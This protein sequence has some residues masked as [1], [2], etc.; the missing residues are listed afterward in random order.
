M[1]KVCKH[2]LQQ[3]FIREPTQRLNFAAIKEHVFFQGVDWA[4]LEN[5]YQDERTEVLKRLSQ[6][7]ETGPE[8]F[9]AIAEDD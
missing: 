7:K 6:I 4:D 2:L 3:I 9:T 8:I 1:S 5:A